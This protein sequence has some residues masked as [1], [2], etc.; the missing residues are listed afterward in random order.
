MK[1]LKYF[2]SFTFSY[3][4]RVRKP[5][6]EI[7]KVAIDRSCANVETSVMVGDSLEADIQGAQSVGLKGI[8]YNPTASANSTDIS[9]D[10]EIHKL[11][12]ILSIL[13]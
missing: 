12:E 6:P 8:W 2:D 1:I 7:F 5:R 13:V 9:P 10:F 3:S 11:S 4:L